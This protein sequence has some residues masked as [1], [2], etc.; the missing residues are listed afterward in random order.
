MNLTATAAAEAAAAAAAA[1]EE[2]EDEGGEGFQS[3]G[4]LLVMSL[5]RA[6]ASAS[7]G[8]GRKRN[9]GGGSGG[10]LLDGVTTGRL[11]EV[12]QRLSH[13]E[14]C[15]ALRTVTPPAAALALVRLLTPDEI[16][17]ALSDKALSPRR[18]AQ[19]LRVAPRDT[20]AS[21]LETLATNSPS[22]AGN[23]LRFVPEAAEFVSVALGLVELDGSAK[24][25]AKNNN[26][27][28]AANDVGK[29][30]VGGGGVSSKSGHTL[31]DGDGGAS[32]SAPPPKWLTLV[33]LPLP[34]QAAVLNEF[35]PSTGWLLVSVSP[36]AD[37]ADPAD[38][39]VRLDLESESASAAAVAR[40][41]A[42]LI[43]PPHRLVTQAA[44]M[45]AAAPVA[46]GIA[47]LLASS[48]ADATAM[49]AAMDLNDK[50]DTLKMRYNSEAVYARLQA[51]QRSVQDELDAD[52]EA[53]AAR[54][55]ASEADAAKTRVHFEAGPL[56][57]LNPV[58]P[59]L[60]SA[61]CVCV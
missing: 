22:K 17:D 38:A 21:A 9:N 57:K 43:A 41:L 48:A 34:L 27:A 37:A 40:T 15:A 24:H 14:R 35:P 10:G 12:I 13:K 2:A 31:V 3:N 53:A 60:K 45:I 23:A 56:Y 50:T 1:Q 16:A 25:G 44:S 47:V 51:S 54:A 30:G 8:K 52:T 46:A 4:Q 29:R 19:I 42:L 26:A 28:A 18:A 5:R 32:T 20:G 59:Q 36:A 6:V 58:D 39:G 11:R 49:L 7:G 33:S 55:A 61:Y